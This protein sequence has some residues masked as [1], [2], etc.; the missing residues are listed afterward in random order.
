MQ[1]LRAAAL[2]LRRND[3]PRRRVILAK[4]TLNLKR[5]VVVALDP[6]RCGTMLEGKGLLLTLDAKRAALGDQTGQRS[7]FS[8]DRCKWSVR[9]GCASLFSANGCSGP[10]ITRREAGLTEA[11]CGSQVRLR[12]DTFTATGPPDDMDPGSDG[13]PI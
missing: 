13:S 3:R 9:H 1:P 6:R 8:L 7:A 2:S 11:G 4:L 5:S 10:A 12:L